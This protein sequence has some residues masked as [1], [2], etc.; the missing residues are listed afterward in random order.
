LSEVRGGMGKKYKWKRGDN[1]GKK[2]AKKSAAYAACTETANQKEQRFEN[3]AP[4]WPLNK[5]LGIL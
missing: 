1:R 2:R 5:T 3:P 4:K